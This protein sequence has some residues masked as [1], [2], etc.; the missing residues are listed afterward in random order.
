MKVYAADFAL[1]LIEA[2]V[3]EALEACACYRLHPMVGNQEM[4]LPPHKDIL[5]L[6]DVVDRHGASPRLLLVWTKCIKL[7]P[8]AEIHLMVGAPVLVLREE[9][10][11]RPDNFAFKI[12]RE[13]GM[14]LG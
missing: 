5:F 10:I 8:V 14:I 2:D 7:G 13:R 9:A 3:I 11:L 12:G 4:L 1:D 6:G